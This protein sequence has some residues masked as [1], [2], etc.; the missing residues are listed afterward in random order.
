M[1]F[2]GVVFGINWGGWVVMLVWW[3]IFSYFFGMSYSI[4]IVVFVFVVSKVYGSVMGK[5]FFVVVCFFVWWY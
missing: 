1:F 4:G 2:D 3:D 5:V